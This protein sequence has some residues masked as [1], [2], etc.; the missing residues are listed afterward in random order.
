V[1]KLYA[2]LTG[3]AQRFQPG[4]YQLSPAMSVPQI[5]A[6]LT[7]GGRN[8]VLVTVPEGS[9]AKD[10]DA[11]LTAAGV[12]AGGSLATLSPQSLSLDYPF[13]ANVASL[14]GFLFPDSY[15][16]DRDA[17]PEEVAHRMLDNFM[18]KS[19]PSLAV[20]DGWY[21]RLILASFLEREVTT[22]ADRELVA[23][24]LLKR[25]RLGM[26]LQV[27]A[28]ISYIKCNGQFRGCDAVKIARADVNLVSNYN[29]Y[30]NCGWTP[31]P[32]ANPGAEALRAAL[33]PVASSYLYYLSS[34]ATG[35]TYF[36]RTLEE[37][38]AK[39]AQYL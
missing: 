27:D 37:H 6:A 35:K 26:P 38:N 31:T 1:F 15:Y 7:A 8:D 12:R 13:L 18:Q 16:F 34:P 11:I 29:T 33:A 25:I 36:S 9:T 19:W 5:V 21:D 24:I 10:V 23:G 32:I 28:T 30:Q 4:T 3:R 14:E 20:M 22:F 2:L 17:A 39:R